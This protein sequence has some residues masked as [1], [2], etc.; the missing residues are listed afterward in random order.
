[1]RPTSKEKFIDCQGSGTERD[2][3]IIDSTTKFP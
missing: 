2:P 3:V 1:M